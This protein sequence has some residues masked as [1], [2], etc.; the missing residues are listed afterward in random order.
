MKDFI[1]K[2][3]TKETL[4]PEHFYASVMKMASYGGTQYIK[5]YEVSAVTEGGVARP[6]CSDSSQ[7]PSVFK[8][9]DVPFLQE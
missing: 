8:E 5:E 1:R 7:G 3:R 6:A 2:W 4:R 9:K